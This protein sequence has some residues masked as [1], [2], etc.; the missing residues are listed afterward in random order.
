MPAV[1]NIFRH[2]EYDQYTYA[3]DAAI[4]QLNRP[5]SYRRP[6]VKMAAN[7]TVRCAQQAGWQQCESRG[8]ANWAH[9]YANES[10]GR[11]GS[12][13]RDVTG[14]EGHIAMLKEGKPQDVQLLAI[15]CNGCDWG[16][17]CMSDA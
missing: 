11:V 17:R 12:G 15:Y 4:L 9:C 5:L 2:P 13:L 7:Y 6:L 10:S 3:N 1:Q 8:R 14:L 16:V